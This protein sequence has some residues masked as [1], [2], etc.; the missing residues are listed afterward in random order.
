MADA[1]KRSLG[2]QSWSGNLSDEPGIMDTSVP[3]AM[4]VY[5]AGKLGKIGADALLEALQPSG[6][7]SNEAGAVFP[8]GMSVPKDKILAKEF[9]SVIPESRANYLRNES[10]A[11]W[12][13]SN[14]DFPAVLKDK[15][16]MLKHAGGN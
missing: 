8:E 2:P 10:L 16:A 11:N 13:A 14:Y 12:H 7:L 1:L 5:G 6:I 3:D 4:M 9:S 15:W